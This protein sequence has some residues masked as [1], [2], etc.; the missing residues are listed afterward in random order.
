[1]KKVILSGVLAVVVAGFAQVGL[2]GSHP[3]A[4]TYPIEATYDSAGYTNLVQKVQRALREEGYYVGT[5]S[6]AFGYETRA[7]IRRYRRDHGL[8]I[9]GKI[10][11]ELLSSL[12][13]K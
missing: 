13:F 2:A 5:T 6:G 9:I 7:A 3:V 12:G 1:M 11:A 10:D 8:A 4:G